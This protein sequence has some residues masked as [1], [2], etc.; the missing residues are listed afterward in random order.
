MWHTHTI[1]YYSIIRDIEILP[2]KTI[3]VDPQGIML[4]EIKQK[5]KEESV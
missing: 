1:G 5:E 2:F 4:G 3:W